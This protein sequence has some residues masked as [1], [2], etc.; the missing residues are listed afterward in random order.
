M[1]LCSSSGLIVHDVS[2]VTLL[3]LA[4]AVNLHY[5]PSPWTM[6]CTHGTSTSHLFAPLPSHTDMHYSMPA[7]PKS[8]CCVVVPIFFIYPCFSSR[9]CC[10]SVYLLC[11][12]KIHAKC[13]TSSHLH[14]QPYTGQS[15]LAHVFGHNFCMFSLV[16]RKVLSP[17]CLCLVPLGFPHSFQ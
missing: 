6:H 3:Q 2:M 4:P 17:I 15:I 1:I 13:P 9:L 10:C 11:C 7:T 5:H 16:F 12:Q 14:R 8:T